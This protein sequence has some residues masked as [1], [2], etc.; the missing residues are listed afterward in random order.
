MRPFEPELIGG[1]MLEVLP[2]LSVTLEVA[3]CTILVG[4]LLGAVLAHAKL[5]HS[6]IPRALAHS[7]TYIMRCTPSIVLLFMVF[8][9]LP[10]FFLEI[11]DYD[12]NDYSRAVFVIVTFTLLYAANISEVMRAAYLAIDRGQY[13][14]AVS[15]GLSPW[16][17]LYRIV[18]PQAMVVALPNFCNSVLNL[19]KEGSLA[20]TIGLI[21]L[22]GAGT[23]IISRAFGASA[24]EVY[25][26]VGIIYWGLAMLLEKS[27]LRL[28]KYLSPQLARYQVSGKGA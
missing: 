16:Q 19:I 15:S 23:L 2:Y 7:Y 24:I 1:F 17:A 10:K 5:G 21:D 9:G 18:L 6:R 4:L 20:Y 11:F 22:L 14:A 27:F 12:I 28:E 26:A 13:E 25:I 8:Y 3:L